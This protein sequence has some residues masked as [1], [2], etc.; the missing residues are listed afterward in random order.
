[1]GIE[2]IK[3]I[4]RKID[5]S[6]IDNISKDER[7]QIKQFLEKKPSKS[8]LDRNQIKEIIGGFYIQVWYIYCCLSCL[9]E[10][11]QLKNCDTHK[12]TFK[13]S[14][15]FFHI[16]N[17]SLAV[18]AC[19]MLATLFKDNFSGTEVTIN[20]I[21]NLC[22]TYSNEILGNNNALE[23]CS[24]FELDL[25]ENW[26]LEKSKTDKENITEEKNEN[27]SDIILNLI[28]R[29]DKSLSHNDLIYYFNNKSAADNNPLPLEE[30]L[31]ITT[32]LVQF[33][34]QLKDCFH[35]STSFDEAYTAQFDDVKRL[36]GEKTEADIWLMS[37]D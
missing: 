30:L 33:S 16:T 31:R 4:L 18:N 12:K 17:K 24:Q 15:I 8:L 29:R 27:K 7:N 35:I 23:I 36:F 2:R 11:D 37:K 25:K 26:I 3:E 22:K 10:L 9:K 28:A 5:F 1:M 14:I 32:L 20:N 21:I 34:E 13:N 19:I 6:K